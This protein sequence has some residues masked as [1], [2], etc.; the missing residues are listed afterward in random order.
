MSMT[1]RIVGL[2]YK[3]TGIPYTQGMTVKDLMDAAANAPG[4]AAARFGYVAAG[5]LLTQGG[6]SVIAFGA[7]YPDGVTSLTSGTRYPAGEYYLAETN[8]SNPR[9]S[10]WQYYVRDANG[11]FKPNPLP[12]QSFETRVLDEGDRVDWRRVEVLSAPNPVPAVY[13]KT[14]LG[15]H[16]PAAGA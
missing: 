14:I 2:F 6:A 10:V 15:E 5:D 1:L 7:R 3:Q 13:R 9:Y 12:L 16:R 11:T 8:V 4:P